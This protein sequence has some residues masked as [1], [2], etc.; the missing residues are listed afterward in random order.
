M[1]AKPTGFL[2]YSRK[3]F[4]KRSTEER[5]LDW[6]E[7][8]TLQA[9][10]ELAQQAARCM[11]CGIP[12]CHAHGCPL[13][14]LIP[15][16]ND[17]VYRGHWREALALLHRTNNFPEVTGRVCPA[18]CETSC[19]L[20]L[21]QEPVSIRQLELAIVEKGW[22]E[23]WITP[24]PAAVK[25]GRRVAIIGSGPAGLAAAQQ[26]ARAGHGVTVF[27]RDERIGGVLRYGIPDFKLDKSVLDRRL[28][29]M[30]A[31]GVAFETGVTVGVDLALSY[32]QRSFHAVLLA[33]GAR[34][35][36]D[37]VVPGRELAGIH[38]AMDFL[39]RQNRLSES[40]VPGQSTEIAA[41]GKRVVVIGGGDTGAD[42]VGTSL[43]Q[44]ATAVTQFEIMPKPPPT[45][46]ESTPWPEWPYVL[47][48]STSHEEGGERRWNI[49]THAFLGQ[50][51]QVTGIRCAEVE[52]VTAENG[53]RICRDRPG[54]EFLQPA[55]LVLLAMGFTREGNSDVLKRFDVELDAA[56]NPRLDAEGMTTRRGVFVT[57]DLAS[58]ASLVVRAI[59][60]GR[61]VAAGMD[62]F[63]TAAP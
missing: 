34:I 35:P 62:H 2:E 38:F 9:P 41:A 5:L 21:N 48:S 42:C 25:S 31:E 6:R 43:R 40:A 22:S 7:V 46:S 8:Q 47:R 56:G 32:L 51:G 59:A 14:N 53:R 58:G 17:M 49:T 24:E 29:Q 36:R 28:A 57:G 11:D 12:F 55:D 19:T 4:A 27:E 61:K 18:P 37:L 39:V 1:C 20:N 3:D 63:L 54:T 15:D 44:G 10:P 50:A 13:G 16:F 52:W 26:L 30:T 60:A 23:G 33:G 45:R